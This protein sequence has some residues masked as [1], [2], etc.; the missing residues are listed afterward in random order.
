MTSPNALVV[1][2]GSIGQRHVRVLRDL[3][4]TVATVSRRGGGDYV[5][6]AD[7]LRQTRP[8]TRSSPPKRRA[9][10]DALHELAEADFRGTVLVE[11]PIF[12]QAGAVPDYPFAKLSSATICASI[13]S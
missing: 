3:G 2:L 8:D 9:T 11:K 12:S 6:I 13:L 4:H 1:G 7:A 10:R 5:S